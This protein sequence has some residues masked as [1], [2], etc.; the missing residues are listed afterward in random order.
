MTISEKIYRAAIP[1]LIKQIASVHGNEQEEDS[2]TKLIKNSKF[3][4]T[5]KKLSTVFAIMS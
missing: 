2:N 5:R 1:L 4:F 3:L